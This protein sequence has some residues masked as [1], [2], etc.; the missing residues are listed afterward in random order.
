MIIW[1]LLNM[2]EVNHQWVVD[3][4]NDGWVI[5]I[6]DEISIELPML[7]LPQGLIEGMIISLTFAI[8]SEATEAAQ[9]SLKVRLDGLTGDDDGGDFSL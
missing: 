8:D 7:L 3:Q 6:K 4:I 9:A 2:T 5:L 1:K